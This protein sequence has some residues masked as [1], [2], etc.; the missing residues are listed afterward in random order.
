MIEHDA[1]I[2]QYEHEKHRP[3]EAEALQHL[4]KIASLVKPI[5]RQRNWRV[6]TLAEFYPPERNLLGVNWNKGQKICLRLRYPSDERQFLPIEQVVDTML[7]ELCH[8]VHGPHNEAFHALWN[9]LRSEH[10]QLIRKG[11]TGEGFLSTGHKLGGAGRIPMQEAR[12]RARAAAERRAVLS[13]GS[14]QKLGGATVRRGEDI[15]K[16]IADAIERR[17]QITKGCAGDRED[18]G[19]G[20]I[21]EASKN[22]FRTKA[23]E[24]DANERAITQAYIELIQEEEREKYGPGYIPPSAE[25]PTGSQG[26]AIDEEAE[27]A[28]AQELERLKSRSGAST[29]TSWTSKPV[30]RQAPSRRPPSPSLEPEPLNREIAPVQD[31]KRLDTWTCTICTLSNPWTFLCCDAC[32]TERSF[33]ETISRPSPTSSSKPPPSSS[34]SRHPAPSR[35]PSS[36]TSNGV[37]SKSRLLGNSTQISE[38]TERAKARER[39]T[40]QKL[41]A[42]SEAENKKPLGWLCHGCG[43]FVESQWWTCNSCG[44]MKLSS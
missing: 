11:Y 6:E 44:A 32:G 17:M 9:Q 30:E 4:R 5:M 14:G 8:N 25:N 34:S 21:E 36:T 27:M 37:G 23:E 19:R 24:D 35:P 7:H 28:A 42:L 33:D 10:E 2:F 13:K 40:I 15:R 16:V 39:S 38:S 43:Q 31:S 20:A 41:S 1:L 26:R 29:P 22:G 12:R 3:R 18:R